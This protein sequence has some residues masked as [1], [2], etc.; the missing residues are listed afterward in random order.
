MLYLPPACSG[1]LPPLDCSS[2]P[3]PPPLPFFPCN[4]VCISLFQCLS[5]TSREL[6]ASQRAAF[7]SFISVYSEVTNLKKIGE[8][9][10][11]AKRWFMMHL[12]N[13]L[14]LYAMSFGHLDY[15]IVIILTPHPSISASTRHFLFRLPL[16]V[17]TVVGQVIYYIWIS[18]PLL[19]HRGV[20]WSSRKYQIDDESYS[21]IPCYTGSLSGPVA[22]RG[23]YEASDTV[24]SMIMNEKQRIFCDAVSPYG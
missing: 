15:L 16:S 11:R 14:P 4:L 23:L 20:W 13:S 2:S 21:E 19:C 6:L 17:M 10:I 7:Q 18:L 8:K 3:S 1:R 22:V 9:H 24:H 5:L 12:I